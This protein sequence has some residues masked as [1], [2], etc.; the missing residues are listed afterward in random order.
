[1]LSVVLAAATGGSAAAPRSKVIDVFPRPNAIAKAIHRASAG[2]TLRIHR[3]IYDEAV[4]VD[5]PLTLQGV[6]KGRRPLIDAGCQ[7]NDTIHVTSAGITIQGLNVKGAASGFGDYPAEIFFD[8]TR[9]GRVFDDRVV[10]TC[11]AEYGSASS[12]PVRW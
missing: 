10:D 1:V 11:D 12:T 7:A 5:K 6:R 3:G 9:S 4:T 2:D 8:G